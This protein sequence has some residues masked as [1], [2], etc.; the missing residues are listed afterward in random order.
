MRLQGWALD[1]ARCVA[2]PESFHYDARRLIL[3]SPFMKPTRAQDILLATAIALPLPIIV[4]WHGDPLYLGLWYYFVVP[5]VALSISFALRSSPLFLT[6]VSLAIVAT[7]LTYM[8]I[9]WRAARPEG[10]LGLGHLFSLPGLV[11]GLI[12][13][14]H[15]SKSTNRPVI[16]LLL[17]LLAALAGF[18]FNQLMVCNTVM[19]CGPLSIV[20]G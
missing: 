17:G 2:L 12:V 8:S 13:G 9:N 3:V 7:L 1:V 15:L 11:I 10:L 5:A 20:R 18:L 6:G 14:A 4:M 19:W 16:A